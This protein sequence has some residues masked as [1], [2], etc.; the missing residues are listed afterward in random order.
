MEGP[1]GCPNLRE[2]GCTVAAGDRK[3][4]C[5][6]DNA[7]LVARIAFGDSYKRAVLLE[8]FGRRMLDRLGAKKAAQRCNR[9]SKG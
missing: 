9:V 3:P 7:H 1:T 2:S 6:M 4:L 5:P 8:Y